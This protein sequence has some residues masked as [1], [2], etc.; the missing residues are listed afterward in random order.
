MESLGCR[1][2]RR[3]WRDGEEGERAGQKASGESSKGFELEVPPGRQLELQL[4]CFTLSGSPCVGSTS[5]PPE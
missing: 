3:T 2:G 5:N 1:E 4:A